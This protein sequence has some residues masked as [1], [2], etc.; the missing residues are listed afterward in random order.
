MPFLLRLKPDLP[1]VGSQLTLALLEAK[2]K[3][4]K[5]TPHTLTVGEG[6]RETFGVFD[7]EFVG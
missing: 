5:I 2:L 1:L 6:G 3:E 7:C 4:H